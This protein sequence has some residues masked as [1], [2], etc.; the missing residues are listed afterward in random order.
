MNFKS[1]K[2]IALLSNIVILYACLL[3]QS[4]AYETYRYIMPFP[5]IKV[6]PLEIRMAMRQRHAALFELIDSVKA[7]SRE[8]K[9]EFAKVALAEMA[10]I[11][12]DLAQEPAGKNG[13]EM[14][15]TRWRDQTVQLANQLYQVSTSITPANDIEIIEADTGDIQVMVDKKIYILSNPK[16]NQPFL[17]DERII[18]TMCQQIYCD[19]DWLQAQQPMKKM[20]LEI[21]AGWELNKSSKPEFVTADG[22]HF[23]FPNIDQRKKKQIASL[24][25]IREI[26]YVTESINQASKNGFEINW[27]ELSIKAMQGTYD[28]RIKLND[29]GDSIYLILPELSHIDGWQDLLMPWIQ[30]QVQGIQYTQY[31]DADEI[32]V[33]AMGHS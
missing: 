1:E 6:Y 3:P 22:L 7:G 18:N 33:Y 16:M 31:L 20:T 32:L 29:F 8:E 5:E 21:K 24:K 30:A 13:Q 11:Y 17:L 27:D 10:G 2:L 9:A 15:I 28:H 23:V 19:A 4:F 25:V 26:E 12:A 14:N